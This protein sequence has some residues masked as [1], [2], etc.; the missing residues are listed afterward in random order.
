[1]RELIQSMP[2]GFL[3]YPVILAMIVVAAR[4]ILLAWRTS[5]KRAGP[6][7]RAATRFEEYDD[8]INQESAHAGLERTCIGMLLTAAGYS[9]YSIDNCRRYLGRGAPEQVERAIQEHLDGAPDRS[10]PRGTLPSRIET[11]L[12][13]IEKQTEA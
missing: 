8:R 1:M 6:I 10:G 9:G 5:G 12:T 11:V 4:T 13:Y 7:G 3:W 2:Q